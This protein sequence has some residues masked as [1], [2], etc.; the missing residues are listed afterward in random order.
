MKISRCKLSASFILTVIAAPFMSTGIAWALDP[1]V[2]ELLKHYRAKTPKMLLVTLASE[3]LPLDQLVKRSTV[4]VMTDAGAEFEGHVLSADEGAGNV[5]L[6]GLNGELIVL[7]F[8][9]IGAVTVPNPVDYASVLAAGVVFRK[10]DEPIPG[11]LELDR[12]M[13]EAGKPYSLNISFD[14]KA[15]LALEAECRRNVRDVL[16]TVESFLQSTSKSEVGGAALKAVGGIELSHQAGAQGFSAKKDGKSV[17]L[18]LD[19]KAAL[20][21]DFRKEVEKALNSAL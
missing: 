8:E 14:D 5:T 12:K 17:T 11:V 3:R 20:S 7:P 15:L 16:S 21:S 1:N 19:C 2:L 6:V 10:A 9:H 4:S 18:T 13:V